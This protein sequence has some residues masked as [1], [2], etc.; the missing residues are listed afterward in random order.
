MQKQSYIKHL[1]QGDLQY[2]IRLVEQELDCIIKIL[3]TSPSNREN[4]NADL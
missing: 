2:I 3:D 4:D 1:S